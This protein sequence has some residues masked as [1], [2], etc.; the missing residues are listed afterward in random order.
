[1]TC[2]KSPTNICMFDRAASPGYI[3]E[4]ENILTNC[5][6]LQE[7]SR[8][9]AFKITEEA[10]NICKLNVSMVC[11]DLFYHTF[12]ICDILDNDNLANFKVIIQLFASTINDDF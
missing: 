7:Q 1:M 9:L 5:E 12:Q 8:I 11:C 10:G 6:E 4:F 2:G 3:R